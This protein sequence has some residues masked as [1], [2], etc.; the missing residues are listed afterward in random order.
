MVLLVSLCFDYEYFD[1]DRNVLRY[2]QGTKHHMLTYRKSDHLVVIGY[3]DS[4]YAGCVDTRIST[5]GYIFLLA[6]ESISWKS[7][8]QYLIA[9][10]TMEAEFGACFKA[11]LQ[12]N[13]L[14]NFILGLGL[15]DSIS[16]PL[17][18][19]CD[20][21]AAVF[22]PKNDKY[23]KGAKHMELKHFSVKEEVQKHKG[24]IEHIS[25]KLMIADPLTK[26]L[27]PKIF[28]EH[29]ER[30]SLINNNE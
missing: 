2:F 18:I 16:K 10:S 30:M 23:S 29:V 9:A 20:N 13:W 3:A 22:F 24:T 17:R 5:F 28:F 11:T 15:V 1:Q 8:K 12:A 26:G 21:T 7:V 4:D 14:Q 19:Y 6:G 25:T 27:P